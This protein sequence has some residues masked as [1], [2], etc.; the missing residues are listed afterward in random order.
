MGEYQYA[1]LSNVYFP[2][3]EN[4]HRL[5]LRVM[6]CILVAQ[7]NF[8]EKEITPEERVRMARI[9]YLKPGTK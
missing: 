8:E 2:D 6:R 3:D 4:F 5:Q 7:E 1:N 9:F